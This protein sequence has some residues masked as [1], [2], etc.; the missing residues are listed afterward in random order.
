MPSA[1]DRHQGQPDIAGLASAFADPRRVRVLVALADGRALPAGRLAQEAGVAASTVSNHL[2]VLLAHELV[3]VE[4][5]GRHRYYRLANGEVE[6]VLSAL[7]ALAPQTPVTSLRE[8]TRA[9]ALRT[10]RTCYHHLAGQAG[11]ELFRRFLGAGWI[12]GG[13]GL[14]HPG[15]DDRL[16]A[17]GRAVDYSL[18]SRG[19]DA[20]AS[21]Q[22][23]SR[24]LATGQPLRYCVDWTEQAH[25]LG[26]PLG[27]AVTARL[28]DLGWIRRGRVPRSIRVT[29]AG[30]EGLHTLVVPAAT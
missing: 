30:R 15:T 14:H 19:A 27:T 11:T 2:S 22:I 18:T 5:Q 4:Q 29:A 12:T 26:G 16:S 9:A 6:R 28:L 13:D 3:T 25:H 23:P 1:C 24:L 8:H 21:W 17:P 20:L 10:A 7:A